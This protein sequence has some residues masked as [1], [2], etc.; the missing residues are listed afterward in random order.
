EGM[1]GGRIVHGAH[2]TEQAFFLLDLP[3]AKEDAGAIL[4][5]LESLDRYPA[6]DE[7]DPCARE[8]ES[9][10]EAWK[11]DGASGFGRALRRAS[12]RGE[13][14]VVTDDDDALRSIYSVAA[15]AANV[16][17]GPGFKFEA[18]G[19]VH[20][21]IS[22]VIERTPA[23]VFAALGA[24]TVDPDGILRTLSNARAGADDIAALR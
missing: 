20:Y 7:D 23:Y 21:S 2:G 5:A 6:L 9:E 15:E 14:V 24:F 13:A 19:G 4:E 3:M 1:A 16:D 22:E 18:G 8:M 12:E 11:D 17:G 10:A